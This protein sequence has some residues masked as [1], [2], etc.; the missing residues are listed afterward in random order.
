MTQ[1]PK[2]D[3]MNLENEDESDSSTPLNKQN[4]NHLKNDI[5]ATQLAI[6][7]NRT[8]KIGVMFNELK[9]YDI[10]DS[11]TLGSS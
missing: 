6:H 4:I 10:R 11:F 9:K 1:R 7:R 5:K 3:L 8:K 2:L